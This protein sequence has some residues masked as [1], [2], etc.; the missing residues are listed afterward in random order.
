M[1]RYW[2]FGA[3]S[4]M[5][6]CA[7]VN[8]SADRPGAGAGR[9]MATFYWRFARQ[10]SGGRAGCCGRGQFRRLL[11]AVSAKRTQPRRGFEEADNR[12]ASIDTICVLNTNVTAA[13]LWAPGLFA[14]CECSGSSCA[15]MAGCADLVRDGGRGSQTE[16]GEWWPGMAGDQGLAGRGS[17]D[18]SS[19]QWL[20]CASQEP[21]CPGGPLCLCNA[22]W[23]SLA[24][25]TILYL[26]SL[27]CRSKLKIG[28]TVTMH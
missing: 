24:L 19:G 4:R 20:Q 7:L 12:Q 11:S 8:C 9:V 17:L 21:G 16:S 5:C 22:N 18:C 6:N 28:V 13:S 23:Y 3:K 10:G 25:A 27:L 14:S 2:V 1:W 26:R 15:N